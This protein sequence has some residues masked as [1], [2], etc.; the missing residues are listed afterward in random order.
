MQS[1]YGSLFQ[2]IAG[3]ITYPFQVVSNCMAVNKSG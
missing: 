1:C 3:T 2:F